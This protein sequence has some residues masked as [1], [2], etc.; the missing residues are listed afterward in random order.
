MFDAFV[1]VFALW[2]DRA[3]ARRRRA[4]LEEIV[5]RARGHAR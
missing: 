4:R 2:R 5:A 1:W 3:S